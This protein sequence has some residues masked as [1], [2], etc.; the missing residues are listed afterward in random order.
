MGCFVGPFLLRE[1]SCNNSPSL[2]KK[3]KNLIFCFSILGFH[4]RHSVIW[5]LST[6]MKAPM[7]STAWSPVGKSLAWPASSQLH[8]ADE[9]VCRSVNF[10][11]QPSGWKLIIPS[12]IVLAVMFETLRHC[13]Q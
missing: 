8:R 13:C 12:S 1:L 4:Y 5:S 3:K 11:P 9:A 6:P 7:T 10:L 2:P